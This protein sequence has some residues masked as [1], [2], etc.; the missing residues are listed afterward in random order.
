MALTRALP[1]N[2]FTGPVSTSSRRAG[3]FNKGFA[4]VAFDGT[5]VVTHADQGEAKSLLLHLQFPPREQ[6]R[7]GG[8]ISSI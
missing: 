3:V 4:K 1:A 7:H 6:D 8:F 2:G 5:Q